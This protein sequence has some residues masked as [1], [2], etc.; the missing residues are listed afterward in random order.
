MEIRTIGID[1]GKT[2]FHAVGLDATGAVVLR[3]R[4]SRPQLMRF[5]VT[6]P[7]CLVGMEAC[8][9]A[10]HMGRALG[11]FG[12]DVRLMPPKY[13]RPFVKA[14]KN[15]YLDAEAIA[16]AVQRPT[17]R[18]VPLKTVDQLD[19]QALHRVRHRLVARRTGVI[20]Q[21]RAFLLERGLT[22][23]TGRE[24]LA[25]VLP[26]VLASAGEALSP[27][28]QQLIER[29]R[30]EWRG[31][32]EEIRDL[33]SQLS[34]IAREDVA[35]QRLV[36]IPGFGALT[37]TALVAAIGKGTTFRKGRD[38]AAWLGLVPLQKTTGGKPTLLGISKRGN[39]YLRRLL[40]Q[41]A[42]SV[43]RLA[44]RHRL[45]FRI[46]LDAL[47][48]RAHPNV[49]AVALANKLV[50]IAW[51]VLTRNVPYRPPALVAA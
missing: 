20:N 28:M 39:G 35:C 27:A 7:P 23:R 50:R 45:P 12:H 4:F 1:L 33:T 34:A 16:E 42:R 15:D 26:E 44:N 9:G 29:L 36:E 3:R 37:A 25:H 31:L 24:H 19:L 17:M 6:L 11:G 14:Q 49:V 2:S 41:G 18:F 47:D 43:H 32:D 5:M 48:A 10:H 40:L 8:C 21:L 38:L 30:E 22:P 46:W 13:V 51:A